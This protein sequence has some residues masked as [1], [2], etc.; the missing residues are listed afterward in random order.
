MMSCAAVSE[1]CCI[2]MVWK[3]FLAY[4][5]L[6]WR[7]RRSPFHLVEKHLVQPACHFGGLAES[8][9]EASTYVSSRSS[10][11]VR[12]PFRGRRGTVRLHKLRK[13]GDKEPTNGYC[14]PVRCKKFD[15][16][17]ITTKGISDERLRGKMRYNPCADLVAA[18]L[19][20]SYMESVNHG[21]MCG[22][23][24]SLSQLTVPCYIGFDFPGVKKLRDKLLKVWV[25]L[26]E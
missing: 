20:P 16:L 2:R 13:H 6:L 25:I 18:K 4:T 3:S 24:D 9:D 21:Q 7:V 15:E 10:S 23:V 8:G 12:G 1:T 14:V 5:W 19:V 17:R 11:L 26:G 22:V